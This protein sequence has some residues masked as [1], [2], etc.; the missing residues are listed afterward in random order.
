MGRT[1]G[2]RNKAT[3]KWLAYWTSKKKWKGYFKARTEY[4]K[5]NP[6]EAIKSWIKP[7]DP[8]ELAGVL[9]TTY[10]IHSIILNT[11]ELFDRATNIS[12]GLRLISGTPDWVSYLPWGN[13][14]LGWISN[15]PFLLSTLLQGGVPEDRAQEII[16]GLV[17]IA[18]EPESDSFLIWA[19][20]FSIAYY[21]QKHGIPDILGTIK[22]FLGLAA[23]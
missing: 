5:K 23:A 1:K 16:D 9:T 20:S 10:V 19:T 3:E 8:I 21:I 18:E 17:K 7:F 22:G 6:L 12:K 11:A 13:T 4:F 14:P 2:A 15:L